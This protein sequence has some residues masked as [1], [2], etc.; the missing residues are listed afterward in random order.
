MPGTVI[1][2]Y[3]YNDSYFDNSVNTSDGSVQFN[4][5][6]VFFGGRLNIP[7]LRDMYIRSHCLMPEHGS[8][9]TWLPSAAMQL[10]K[11]FIDS[12]YTRVAGEMRQ[13]NGSRAYL[14]I[15]EHY[16]SASLVACVGFNVPRTNISLGSGIITSVFQLELLTQGNQYTLTARE[17]G[18]NVIP[19]AP[20]ASVGGAGTLMPGLGRPAWTMF[21]PSSGNWTLGMVFDFGVAEVPS[22][23][24][25]SGDSYTMALDDMSTTSGGARRDLT[26]AFKGT[27]LTIT[28][29]THRIAALVAP[30][31][32]GAMNEAW[33]FTVSAKERFT[34]FR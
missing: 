14:A 24:I 4:T 2:P 1:E 34:Y 8:S 32:Q 5:S 29:S 20:I 28:P 33:G 13:T 31:D 25:G 15:F 27:P 6:P 9:Q 23:A 3:T 7:P 30:V 17:T 12:N 21:T 11:D 26:S 10:R 18:G 16:T 19:A 22:V